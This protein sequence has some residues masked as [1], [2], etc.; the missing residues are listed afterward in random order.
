MPPKLTGHSVLRVLGFKP[1][2]ILP[3]LPRAK[4][5]AQSIFS[6]RFLKLWW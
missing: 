1:R 5:E 6:D 3:R 2:S 4:M